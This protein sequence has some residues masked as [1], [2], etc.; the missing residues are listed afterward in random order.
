MT[1]AMVSEKEGRKILLE[2]FSDKIVSQE[3]ILNFENHERTEVG[4]YIT[5]ND[6]NHTVM[7]YA[8]DYRR[9]K[10]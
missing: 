10:Q 8:E 6:G 4:L 1:I 5:F 9:T 7:L 3:P 2:Q